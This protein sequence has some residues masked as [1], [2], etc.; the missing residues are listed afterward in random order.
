MKL[1]PFDK[2]I[3]TYKKRRGN[4]KGFYVILSVVEEIPSSVS[5]GLATHVLQTLK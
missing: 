3:L 5:I 4:K 2:I 1:S